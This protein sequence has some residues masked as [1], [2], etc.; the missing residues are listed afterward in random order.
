MQQSQDC[1]HALWWLKVGGGPQLVLGHL[2][3]LYLEFLER[4]ATSASRFC[5]AV[6]NLSGSPMRACVEEVVVG[7][8]L[9]HSPNEPI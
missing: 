5:Q 8:P 2:F 9:Q 4:K 3:P 6:G 7:P 1:S